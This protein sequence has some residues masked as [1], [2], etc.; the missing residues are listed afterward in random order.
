M[1]L[2]CSTGPI[3]DELCQLDHYFSG[4]MGGWMDGW[5]VGVGG[6]GGEGEGRGK[7][8]KVKGESRGKR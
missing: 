3:I 8:V 1:I 7:K 4:R 2:L 6:D 5:V